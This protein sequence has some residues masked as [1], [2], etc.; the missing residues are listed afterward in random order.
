MAIQKLP[1]K[2]GLY[3]P[4]FEKDNCGV[5]FVARMD[6]VKTY[7]TIREALDLLYRLEHRGACGSDP[8]TGDGAGILIQIPHEFFKKECEKIG[9]DL[10]E[11]GQYGTGLVFFP[12][13]GLAPELMK[14]FEQVIQEEGLICL[15]WRDVPVDS[16]QC[17]DVA[18]QVEP[19][20]KQLFVG[21]AGVVHDQDELERKLYVVRK[22]SGQAIRASGLA[23]LYESYY[24][25]S[26]SSK[27]FVYKGQLMAP[28]VEHYF[29]DIQDPEMKTALALVHSRYSTNTF[30]SW[31]RAQPMRMVAHNGEINTIRGNKN[32][33]QAREAMMESELFPDID[34]VKPVIPPGGSD[35]ADFDQALE[36]LVMAGRSLP[37][38]AQ[39]MIPEPW[40]GHETMAQDKRDFFEYHASLMEPWDGP[41]SI[42][43]TD[44]E[45]VG[46]VLDRNGLRPSRYIVT[47][48]GK[49]V[50]ASEVG[51]LPIPES[52]IIK[53]GRLQPGKM[54]FVD[55]K[56]GRILADEE[57]KTD[58]A[59][60]KPYGEWLK[61]NQVS[62]DDL[63]VTPNT[64]SA[65]FEDLVK[66]QIAFGFT[67]EDIK[68][69]LA[70]MAETGMEATGSMGNDA[71]LAV[72]SEKPVLL[73]NYFKQL[74]AQVTNPAIDSIREE[75]VMSMYVTLGREY[76]LLSETPEQCRKLKLNH[77]ILTP[78]EIEK[79]RVLDQKDIKTVTLSTLF[80]ASE[81]EEGMERALENLCAQASEAIANGA[82]ILLLSDRG[83][84]EDNAPLP[85]LL[86]TA[87]V[88]HHLL[89]EGTRML[90]GIA[91]ET[92]EAREMHHFALLIG[93]GAGA[94]YPYMAYDTIAKIAS[95]N[96]FIKDIA[97][98]AA[99]K[100]FITSCRKGL[101]KII[102]KMG[103]ST[104]Q[105]YRGAQIFEAV[106]LNHSVINQYFSG[107]PSRI[108]GVGIEILAREVLAR[109]RAAFEGLRVLSPL[110]D[111]GGDYYWRRGEQK[112]MFNPKVIG[113]LQ[114]ATRS[115]D[116]VTFKKF[117]K[118][119]D[120]ENTRACTLRGLFTF[121][122][123]TPVPI[124]EVEPVEEITRRF[125]TG[126]M[127]IGSISREA[128]ETLA[129]AMNRLGGKSNTGE[130]GEDSVRYTPDP[131]GDS[132]RSAIKQVASGRFGV[133]SYY[134]T[135]ADELQ[136]KVS[137]GAKP[138]EGGQLPGHKV[139][140]YI[141]RIRH[142]TP[143]VGL[144]SPPPHHD[145]YS[146][147]DL[148]QLI[149]D[150]HNSNPK[151]EVS[152]KLVAESG[153]GTIAA[154]VSK[155]RSDGVL[156]AGHDGGT[157]ASPQTSIKHAGLPWELGLSE[158]QQVLV[159]NDLRGR[160]RVQVDGQLKTGRDVVIGALLGADSF[161]FSTAPL[162]TMGC[163]MMR[164]CH[165]N[166]CSVGIATQDEKLRKK[167]SGDAD[168]VVNFFRFIA[169]E[170]R[171]IM[172]QLG[173]RK[174]DDIIGRSDLLKMDAAIGH[175][176]SQGLDFSKILFKPE[177]QPNVAIRHVQKQDLDADI[178]PNVMDRTLIAD[179]Q[180]AL[181]DKTPYAGNYLIR[182]IDRAVG[183]MLS[184]AVSQRYGEEGLPEKTIQM[185]FGG[186]AGQSFGGFLAPGIS[187]YLYGDANDYVGKG[188][189]G[190]HIVVRPALNSPIVPEENIIAGNVVLYGAISG[191]AFFRGVAGERFC[192]RNSGAQT[193][194]EGVGDH[195]CEY[196]T[197]GH[198]VVLGPTGRN[199]A[200]GMSGGI[201]YV[202]DENDEFEIHCNKGLVDLVP[203]EEDDVALVTGLVKEH[204]DLTGSTVGERVLK[205]WDQLQSKFIKV[206]PRD[207]RRVLE[208]RKKREQEQTAGVN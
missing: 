86:A 21:G 96:V 125:C 206:Y 48:D 55:L 182:N 40:A 144:I 69:V 121:K 120:E 37:H 195:A 71:A 91:V 205:D 9:I 136:I 190:G 118:I 200:A 26:L 132:R 114:H 176:K 47:K 83:V 52:E 89:R 178:G 16:T 43:F 108:E 12:K 137:Q 184:N 177:T 19:L 163:I 61:E 66:R 169:E 188:L 68:I 142:S 22:R 31:G 85:S 87:A 84:D 38:A 28:Q 173:F 56:Q 151:A 201:A 20:M 74:F 143:G 42:T 192:V 171:E 60:Q 94:I 179:A 196:M 135:N 197:G 181:V 124:E 1:E 101:Y 158:T 117:S 167:F 97:I 77:P 50:M 76:N 6:G 154:G 150:L 67:M 156:I 5:G 152:V 11:T 95:E 107:T 129:I 23:E 3:D 133:N 155:A 14:I 65:N 157:G 116:Y 204:V 147:E 2:Q 57:I 153:V 160:I 203:L 35:T 187:F 54:F 193:V 145:I 44:G 191:K 10:P 4:A 72:R 131:N 45:V 112:H 78:E 105:S 165:L 134:L 27:T 15:G 174:F 24:I 198:V 170:V 180:E 93:Y 75:L 25:C 32:W 103:I 141:A 36:F 148:Q 99:I 183:A 58:L 168:Y 185:I 159:M 90:C 92:G 88:H 41:A 128:H 194:V 164:K 162:V 126:A 113:L 149:F 130:G 208:E 199:F 111:A 146:I 119:S 106:G 64:K 73:F 109:H 51:V 115:N 34:T 100:N 63:P 140:E 122:D 161:G 62:I 8:R 202:L 17:G 104:I 7:E 166:T 98:E 138:G 13:N 102:A 80:P 30:P 186:S 39:M 33:I 18:R 49:V 59:S 79:I 207:F 172:A 175:W 189:S 29:K 46:A 110:I 53:K 82:T 127:S 123:S 70:P 81:G 139:S